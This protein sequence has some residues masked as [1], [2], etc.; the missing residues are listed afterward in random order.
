[1]YS[2]YVVKTKHLLVQPHQCMAVHVSNHDEANH[3]SLY[4]VEVKGALVLPSAHMDRVQAL[5][6]NMHALGRRELRHARSCSVAARGAW[7]AAI[8]AHSTAPVFR[9]N[10]YWGRF[11]RIGSS[12]QRIDIRQPSA[13]VTLIAFSRGFRHRRRSSCF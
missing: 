7:A 1:M 9:G 13:R 12:D 8:V 11:Q 4:L 5:D 10:R 2:E 3:H 6:P